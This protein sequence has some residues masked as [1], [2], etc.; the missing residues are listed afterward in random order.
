M[1][2]GFE[3]DLADALARGEGAVGDFIRDT[4]RTRNLDSFEVFAATARQRLAWDREAA[5]EETTTRRR[6]RRRRGGRRRRAVGALRQLLSRRG[7]RGFAGQATRFVAGAAWRG[8]KWAATKGRKTAAR[9]TRRAWKATQ[10]QARRLSRFAA[11]QS[12]RWRQQTFPVLYRLWTGKHL[13]GKAT[14]P[15]IYQLWT[16]KKWKPRPRPKKRQPLT[17]PAPGPALAAYFAG[18]TEREA[19]YTTS[20]PA[21]R[22]PKA[23][24]PGALDDFRNETRRYYGELQKLLQEEPKK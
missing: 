9:A 16:G 2:D 17:I 12:R 1:Y 14:W 3:R 8:V 20:D 4:A 6:R 10:R 13:P 21:I 18:M 24:W 19:V 5:G 22:N 23:D 7:R 15:V 11:N